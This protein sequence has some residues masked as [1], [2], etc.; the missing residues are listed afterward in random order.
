MQN[1]ALIPDISV[2]KPGNEENLRPGDEPFT[3]SDNTA[4]ITIG[5][6]AKTELGA[7]KFLNPNSVNN[8]GNFKISLIPEEGKPVVEY[9]NGEVC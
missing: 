7:T 6:G 3:V 4:T 2:D 5:F 9:K 8:V 1:P